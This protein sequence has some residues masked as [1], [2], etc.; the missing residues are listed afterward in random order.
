[1]QS[2]STAAKEVSRVPFPGGLVEAS[3]SLVVA[4]LPLFAIGPPVGF[5]SLILVVA[6]VTEEVTEGL[7]EEAT[8]EPA[9]EVTDEVADCSPS[10]GTAPAARERERTINED[11]RILDP[12]LI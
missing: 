12:S 5:V 6:D 8:E 3:G 2:I 9:E 1:M 11:I 4:L 7:T 10:T